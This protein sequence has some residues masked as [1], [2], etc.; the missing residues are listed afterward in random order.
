MAL[1]INR[2]C[3]LA[4]LGDGLTTEQEP[5]LEFKATIQEIKRAT[6]HEG[7]LTG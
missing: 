2:Q 7:L 5:D 1:L 4:P 3:V 6:G